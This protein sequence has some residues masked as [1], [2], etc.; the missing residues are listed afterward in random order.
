MSATSRASEATFLAM[1]A[2]PTDSQLLA[3][4]QMAR[5]I[6]ANFQRDYAPLLRL[7]LDRYSD[8]SGQ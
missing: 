6:E 4:I 8:H 5:P 1:R 2:D 7:K 3:T